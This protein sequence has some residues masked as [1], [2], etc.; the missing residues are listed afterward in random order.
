MS[1]KL[2]VLAASLYQMDAIKTAKRLGYQVVTTD[3]NPSNPGHKLADKSYQIDTTNYEAI[4]EMA[5]K[6]RVD[7]VISPGT[8]VSVLTAA[9]VSEALSIPGVTAAA[10][11]VLTDKILFREFL[12]AKELP[13][14]EAFSVTKSFIIQ[15]NVFN[16]RRF[17]LK[18]NKSS[19][20]K[21]V[22]VV[23]NLQELNERKEESISFS[24]DKKAILERFVEGTQQTAEGIIKRGK[25]ALCVI[26]DRDT[27]PL[28][29]SATAGHR[30]PSR[31][32]AANRQQL[33]HL[34]ENICAALKISDTNFDCDFIVAE[35][36]IY[37]LE[38]TPR[39]GGNSLSQLIRNSLGFD[40]VEYAVK[41]A[42]G[43][44]A[45]IP[46][47]LKEAPA[48]V[49]ILGTETSGALHYDAKGLQELQSKAWIKSLTLEAQIGE[50]VNAFINGRHRVGEAFLCAKDRLELD[51][52]ISEFH[53]QLSLEA[54]DRVS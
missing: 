36:D 34:V 5:R 17:I 10:A 41:S 2:L 19:G 21:G 50:P 11:K 28:P 1:K 20:S 46:R 23:Q 22:F 45:E 29:Y 39:L 14:P 47:E 7:G 30:I 43:D 15:D 26:T 9:H 40:L 31:I 4:I 44:Y 52:Y 35:S 38:I 13:H 51:L 48:A 42:C 53:S 12:K 24:L 33:I 54:R 6:E 49:I 32:T 8:D 3:N 18:P 37:M 16:G 27:A 25:V